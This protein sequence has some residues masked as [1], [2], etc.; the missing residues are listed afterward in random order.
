MIARSAYAAGLS[1][2]F[3]LQS[4]SAVAARDC[5]SLVSNLERLACFDEAA[6]TPARVVSQA[7]S[8]PEQDAPSVSR[9]MANEAD[10]SVDD[11]AFRLG[12]SREDAGAAQPWL[13]ISAPA[14]ASAEPRSYLA[15]SCIQNISRLQLITGQPLDGNRVKVQLRGE[16]GATTA[17]AWQVME[18][19]RVLDAGRGLPAIEQIKQLIGAHRVQV[20]SDEPGVDG[21]IFDAQGLDPLIDQARKTCRW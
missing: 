12:S 4:A 20:T 15:I 18:N 19:G 10:R 6:G 14:I 7:W 5:P 13:V 16:L 8:A 17:T 9:V 11:L 21:L 2:L 1:L 3:V